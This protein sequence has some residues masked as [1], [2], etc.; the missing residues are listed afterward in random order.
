MVAIVVVL[1]LVFGTG[2]FL[3]VRG[4]SADASVAP[5][6]PSGKNAGDHWHAFLGVNVC[7]TWLPNAPEFSF[8]DDR[9]SIHSHGD[10]L[11]HIHP[12]STSYS[13]KKATVSKFIKGGGWSLSSDQMKLWDGTQHKNGQDCPAGSNYQ[14]LYEAAATATTTPAGSAEPTTTTTVVSSDEAQPAFI[15]WSVNG[16]MMQ[17]NPASY[18]PKNGDVIA[19]GFL[20]KGVPLTEPPGAA[21]A[22]GQANAGL[23]PDQTGGATATGGSGVPVSTATVPSSPAPQ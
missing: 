1:V 17:G 18:R 15:V 14:P 12:F 4:R 21:A 5:K 11:I 8:P 2:I 22:I 20:P 7:G 16:K 13:G 3:A 23:L 6:P 9:D 19:I 10:G